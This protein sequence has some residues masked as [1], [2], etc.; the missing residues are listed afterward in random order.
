MLYMI[1]CI[2]VMSYCMFGMFFNVMR[3]A[4]QDDAISEHQRVPSLLVVFFSLATFA[5]T[6]PIF[7]TI[8]AV[9]GKTHTMTDVTW[10]VWA[11]LLGSI[12]VFAISILL[13][14]R[15]LEN[16]NAKLRSVLAWEPGAERPKWNYRASARTCILCFASV[17]G[18]GSAGSHLAF[19]HS[20]QDGFANFSFLKQA[21]P[22]HDMDN[23]KSEVVLMQYRQDAGPVNYRCPTSIILGGF[24]GQ[25][26]VP[27]PDFASGS[28]ED[29][30][31]AVTDIRSKYEEH[32]YSTEESGQK[33]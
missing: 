9:A 28:S 1:C 12:A 7:Q 23:C 19:F 29:L 30:G 10:S 6:A 5:Y 18:I 20:D 32:D 14:I 15:D 31:K 13:W 3:A 17:I 8:L 33:R 11:L 16:D 27:W 25:P 2:I 4:A 24:S 21:Y 26:F 22:I